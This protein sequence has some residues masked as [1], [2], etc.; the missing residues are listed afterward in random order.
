MAAE[1][2]KAEFSSSSLVLS[3]CWTKCP[4][5]C[6]VFLIECKVLNVIKAAICSFTTKFIEILHMAHVMINKTKRLLTNYY[7]PSFLTPKFQR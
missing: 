7:F 2:Q 5:I 3:F 1:D 6:P 4:H